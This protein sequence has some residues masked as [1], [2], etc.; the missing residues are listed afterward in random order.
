LHRLRQERAQAGTREKMRT[1]AAISEH[2]LRLPPRIFVPA[3]QTGND[4]GRVD[5]EETAYAPGKCEKIVAHLLE[6]QHADIL[7]ADDIGIHAGEAA[8]FEMPELLV[9][10][11]AHHVFEMIGDRQ[12]HTQ[13]VGRELI[14]AA[15]R[16]VIGQEVIDLLAHHQDDAN[17]AKHV[18][19]PFGDQATVGIAAPKAA[20]LLIGQRVDLGGIELGKHRLIGKSTRCGAVVID[21][22]AKDDAMNEIGYLRIG[23]TRRV[24][25]PHAEVIDLWQLSEE[26]FLQGRARRL[27]QPNMDEEWR[28]P[29][30][31]GILSS[32][33]A[34]TQ[35]SAISA[36]CRTVSPL[37]SAI[38]KRL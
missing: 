12:A 16:D 11:V 23:K 5:A 2:E 18:F 36:S 15:E 28:P 9:I 24:V 29:A 32:K 34:A 38:S 6:E 17:I 22:V 14:L 1:Q 27:A 7:P 37:R 3:R 21:S 26:T 35:V 20:E 33:P 4:R 30:H 10:G 13:P 31:D 8:R 25:Q 19:K